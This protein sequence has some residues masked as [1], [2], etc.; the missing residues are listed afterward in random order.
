V[1]YAPTIA[2]LRWLHDDQ[3]GYI[4]IVAGETDPTDPSKIKLLMP[5]RD[6]PDA[7]NT[8]KWFYLDPLRPDLYEAADDYVSYLGDRYGN[9]YTGVRQYSKKQR[10]E[11]TTK[12]SRVIFI[13][14][15]P[16]APEIPYS[17]SI[18]TSEHSRH[19][20]YKCDQNVTKDDARR[21]A[22]ALEGADSSGVDLTQLVRFPGTF[23]TKNNQRW[24]VASESTSRAIYSLDQ[25][26]AT[27]PTVA[28]KH[29]GAGEITDLEWPEVEAHLSNIDALY[30]SSRFKL[31]KPETQTGRIL[32]GEML[33]FIVKGKPDNSRSMN[34]CAVALG[35]LLR[36]FPDD[37]IAAVIFD[38]YRKWGLEADKG[39]AW[40][41]N[42]GI[43]SVIGEAHEKHPEARQSPTHY[44]QAAAPAPIVEH[45]APSRARSDRPRKY[46]AL[47]LFNRY[48]QQPSICE[49]SRKPRAAALSISTAT[50]DRLEDDLESLNLIEI[51]T[52]GRGLPGRV[53]LLGGVINIAD[54]GCY[55]AQPNESEARGVLVEQN[56]DRSPV[57]IGGTLPPPE[58]PRSPAPPALVD[59]IRWAIVAMEREIADTTTGNIYTPRTNPDRVRG[60]IAEHYPTLDTVELET[61]YLQVRKQ[62][63]AQRATRK[64]RDFWNGERRRIGALEDGP[65]IAALWGAASRMQAAQRKNPQSPWAKRCAALFAIHDDERRRR[66]LAAG[67]SPPPAQDRPSRKAAKARMQALASVVNAEPKISTEDSAPAQIGFA[68]LSDQASEEDLIWMRERAPAKPKRRRPAA[69]Q[70][71]VLPRE[72]SPQSPAPAGADD[73]TVPN[74]ARLIAYAYTLRE[75]R[76]AVTQ[77]QGKT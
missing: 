74:V 19:A 31:I 17:A 10:S 53:I 49:L 35:L 14:D 69:A 45:P 28:E 38:L 48:R 6:W 73:P 13:D 25:I 9:V 5:T 1:T 55:Q 22:A 54:D 51:K 50:L 24:P 59:A 60:W 52:A 34:G 16:E 8:R 20:Y 64:K 32:A 2:F 72:C 18:R 68:S 30:R 61:L 66:G 71:G 37:E 67:D 4:E 7:L 56:D 65:L 57:S 12:P 63:Q 11:A 42:I 27:F 33:T 76:Q 70:Q 47:M 21:A 44:K 36:G 15:A 46:D 23:N 75:Q 41:K 62:M 26:R 39:T 58:T 40:V 29:S 77:Q 43:P 3:A